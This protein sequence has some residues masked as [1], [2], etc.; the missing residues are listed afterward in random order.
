M[1]KCPY[2]LPCVVLVDFDFFNLSY[3]VNNSL[4]GHF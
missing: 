1:E 4:Q 2:A 3:V